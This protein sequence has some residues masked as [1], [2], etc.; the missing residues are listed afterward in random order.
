MLHRKNI[1][2]ISFVALNASH[3]DQLI[4]SKLE[5]MDKV[6]AEHRRKKREINGSLIDTLL[7]SPKQ[8]RLK[9]RSA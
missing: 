1:F 9:Q 8:L 2:L 7:M 4:A 6:I 5:N 3:R